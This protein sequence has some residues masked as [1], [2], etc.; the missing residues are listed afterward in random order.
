MLGTLLGSSILYF[1]GLRQRKTENLS[2]PSCQLSIPPVISNKEA[3]VEDEACSS[4]SEEF[5][6]TYE[7]AGSLELP[8]PNEILSLIMDKL[9][10][11]DL[12]I[13][14][15][16]CKTLREVGSISACDQHLIYI[17]FELGSEKLF[18]AY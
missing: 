4:G 5:S 7:M 14:A 18:V 3:Q 10:P 8:L 17:Y 2:T 16:V 13:I 15:A 1:F 11:R 6:S 12:A 9:E